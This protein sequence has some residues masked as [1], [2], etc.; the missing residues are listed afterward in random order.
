MATGSL[1]RRVRDAESKASCASPCVLRARGVTRK[2]GSEMWPVHRFSA[3]IPG[4]YNPNGV[5]GVCA[6]GTML[7]R[8]RNGCPAVEETGPTYELA[9][10][11]SE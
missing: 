11:N 9:G 5:F 10:S 6:T 3:R 1:A 7:I 8:R 2:P 4:F